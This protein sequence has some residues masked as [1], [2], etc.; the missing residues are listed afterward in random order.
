MSLTWYPVSSPRQWKVGE[1][2]EREEE[3]IEGKKWERE[4]KREDE[5]ENV[6]KYVILE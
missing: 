1:G 3:E 6:R 5:R 4:R 2:R